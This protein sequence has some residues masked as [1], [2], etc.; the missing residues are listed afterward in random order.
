MCGRRGTAILSKV[1]RKGLTEKMRCKQ[2][3]EGG[4][5]ERMTGKCSWQGKGC[6]A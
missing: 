3:I 4:E 5:G 6:E 1:V 2:R